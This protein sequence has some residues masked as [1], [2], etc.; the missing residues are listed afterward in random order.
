MLLAFYI[1]L[2][3]S[4]G[5]KYVQKDLLLVLARSSPDIMFLQIFKEGLFN[6]ICR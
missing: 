6:S 2:M 3:L 1:V 4:V 5:R